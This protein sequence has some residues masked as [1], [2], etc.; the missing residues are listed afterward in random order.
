M[1]TQEII[2]FHMSDEVSQ[3]CYMLLQKYCR[4]KSN[5]M[6]AK[7]RNELFL[8]MRGYL[9]V[10]VNRI[11]KKWGRRERSDEIMSMTWEVFM[12]GITYYKS[13]YD[14]IPAHFYT[15][16][17]YCLLLHY[18]KQESVR[19]PLDELKTIMQEFPTLENQCFDKLLTL[20]QFRDV[21]PDQ[22]RHIW[23]DAMLSLDPQ[24]KNRVSNAR[25]N[26]I[27]MTAYRHMRKAFIP[28]IKLILGIKE[29]AIKNNV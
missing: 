19:V 17:R 15:H 14:N 7:V 11:L 25:G 28:I 6:R 16:A 10:W 9:T 13:H 23:D 29:E 2:G 20:Y 18:A 27:E 26:G 5:N 1:G 22:Y 4:Y 12:F 3:R 24:C 21:V 8:H